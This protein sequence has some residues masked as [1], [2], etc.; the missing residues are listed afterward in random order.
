LT[1]ETNPRG[2][3]NY[4]YDVLGRRTSLKVNNQ[5]TLNYSYDDND[6][7]TEI[8]EGSETFGFSYDPLD[9][10][11]GMTL[12]NGVNAAYSYDAVGRLTGMKYSKG[13]T[14]L[15]DL[16]YG[17]DEI[18]RR[19]S[20]SGNTAPELQ[21]TATDTAT[22]NALNQYTTLNGKPVAHDDNGNQTIN[23]AVWD[24]R[25]R[26]VSLNGPNFTASFTYDALDRRTSKTVNGQTKTYLYAGDD[27]ISETGADYTFGPGIDQPLERKSGQN[28]Y[29]LSDALSSVIGLTDPSGAIKTSYN[30]SPFGKKQTTGTNSGNPFAF[31][32]RED[33]GTGYYYYRARYYSPDQKRFIS[34]D[35][36][37]FGGGDSNLQAYVG[38][39]PINSTDPSGLITFIIPGG[40]NEFGS[41]PK[42]ISSGA[43]YNVA[44]IPNPAG[45]NPGPDFTGDKFNNAKMIV[46]KALA[47]G[48]KKGE[49]INIIAHSDGNQSLVGSLAAYLR[50][51]YPNVEIDVGRLD[52]TPVGKPSKAICKTVDFLSNKLSLREFDI[53]DF[54]GY[55]NKGDEG[56]VKASPG[57]SHMDLL[58]DPGVLNEMKARFRF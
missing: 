6:R 57:V 54:I 35:P 45:S 10:R 53:R 23:S 47:S 3:V 9:R 18:N 36:L 17:Y 48:L 34:E 41:L 40:G 8:S 22:V 51:R 58:N 24:V 52:P 4:T 38:N 7:L 14:V 5:R 42:N 15:R 27:L 28:E 49:P 11:A 13:S 25:D 32:G 31:T 43:Q 44:T 37:G 21:E 2:T 55:F 19:T 20:Y 26:L 1:Q 33:D 46:D 30:Y 50:K 56:D 16:V 29:Y 39:N 12:P